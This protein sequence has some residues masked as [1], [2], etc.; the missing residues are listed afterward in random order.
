MRAIRQG[1]SIVTTTETDADTVENGLVVYYFHGNV[2][3]PTCRAIEKQSHDTVSAD[4]AAELDRGQIVWKALNYEQ[5][6]GES[7]QKKFEV[8]AP[9]VVLARMKDGQ[10]GEW[11]RLDRVW[12]LVDEEP[13]F[14]KYIH[15]EIAAMLAKSE[16]PTA[17]P[18][19]EVSAIPVPDT[20]AARLE[21]FDRVERTSLTTVG[22]LPKR[23]WR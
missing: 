8:I 6:A 22:A 13:A 16:T 19:A 21:S 15:A 14:R 20:R 11:K 9:V 23:G 10:M 5:P 18:D 7:L 1:G 2:R 17:S 3:C 12:L 4:F